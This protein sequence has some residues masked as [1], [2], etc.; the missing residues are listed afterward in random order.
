VLDENLNEEVAEEQDIV[1]LL[2]AQGGE[3]EDEVVVDEFP[4]ELPDDL[5]GLKAMLIE[6]DEKIGKRNKTI[7]KRTE[8][9]HRMQDEIQSLQQQIADM[10]NQTTNASTM[11]AQKQEYS[12]T[13]EKWRNSVEEDPSKA[14]DFVTWQ[15]SETQD[16]I[17]NYLADMQTKF[18]ARLAEIEGGMNPERMQNRE[19]INKLKQNPRFANFNDDQL[20]AVIQATSDIKPRG[21]VTG[22]PVVAKPSKE[23]ALE[24]ARELA[25]KHFNG[26][27]G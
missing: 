17:V 20:L 12:E 3:V 5:D 7:K 1:D 4:T 11:E 14:V 21:T 18:D 10:K 27:F 24:H 6:R 19:K 2:A 8:A 25:K 22:K 23:K 15:N 13:L 26:T 16:K 9:T